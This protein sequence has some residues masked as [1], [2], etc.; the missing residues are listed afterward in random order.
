MDKSLIKNTAI[1]HK[2]NKMPT[3]M[4]NFKDCHMTLGNANITGL[5]LFI[6]FI[7]Y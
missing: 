5:I 7:S 2:K 3:F 6:Y 1:I 4:A